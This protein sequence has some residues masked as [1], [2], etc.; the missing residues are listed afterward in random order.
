MEDSGSSSHTSPNQPNPA[1]T[2]TKI[3][4]ETKRDEVPEQPRIDFTYEPAN[5]EERKRIRFSI[6]PNDLKTS[7]INWNVFPSE[8]V[9]NPENDSDNR[10]RDYIFSSKGKYTVTLTVYIFENKHE[11]TKEITVASDDGLPSGPGNPP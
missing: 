4:V 2:T 10:W 6:S 9:S 1:E 5:P 7:T 8:N 11:V 3:N